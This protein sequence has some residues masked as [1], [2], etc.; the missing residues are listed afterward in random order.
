MAKPEKAN[1]GFALIAKD[2]EKTLGPCLA[3]IAPYVKQLVVCIDERT[4]DKTARI[5]R[6]YGAQVFPVKV[7]DWHECPTHG[8]VLAQD[9]AQ[10]RDVSFS[11]LD[12]DIEWWGWLDADDE[13]EGAEHLPRLLKNVPEPVI[14]FWSPYFYAYVVHEDGTRVPNTVFHRE[15]IFRTKDNEWKWQHRV[16]EVCTPKRQGPWLQANNLTWW[17]QHQQHKV[18]QSA[19]RNLLLLE[20]EYEEKPDDPRTVFYIGNQYFALGDWAPAADWYERYTRLECEKNPYELW[21]T[22]VYMSMAYER[23]GDLD[24]SLQAAHGAIDVLPQHPEPYYRLSQLAVLAGEFEK[25]IYWAGV[26]DAKE[27]PP[28]FVFKNPMDRSFNKHM[29]VADALLELGRIS[30]A[31]DTLKEALKSFKDERILEKLKYCEGREADIKTA[32]AY[33]TMA[34]RIGQDA[35][36]ELYKALPDTVKS[37]GRTRNITMTELRKRRTALTQPK[38]A[39]WCMAGWEP[40]APPSINGTG[41]GGSETAVIE[42]AKRFAQAGWLV[43]VYNGCDYMEGEYDGV[44]YWDAQRLLAGE[45]VDVLV[46][47]RQPEAH[48][49]DVK[50]R[51]KVL[52][53]HD[54]N[55]GP[56]R[57]EDFAA[58]DHVL[59]VSYWHAKRLEMYHGVAADY[60]PNGINLERFPLTKK[61][62]FRCVYASSPDRGLMKLLDL[63]PTIVAAEPAATL[64][65]AYGWDTA[66]KMIQRG[67]P[68]GENLLRMRE[69][70]EA[71]IAKLKGVTWRGRLPQDELAK[72]YSEAYLW[73]YP[74]DFL[75]VSCISAMESM[76][77][78]AVPVTTACGALPET[79]GASGLLVPSPTFSRGYG[80]TWART[81]IGLM[82]DPAKRKLYE[83]RGRARATE[84]TWDA[85]FQRW[86]D[87]LA[88]AGKGNKLAVASCD[89]PSV[90]PEPSGLTPTAPDHAP[91]PTADLVAA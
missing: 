60:V 13:L 77:G 5:A 16:H 17:H 61:V 9:F 40:W 22:Y 14:G 8:K 83:A 23:L 90:A 56:G 27:D 64:H 87:V 80:E 63:W 75:E 31:K 25:G 62:P 88:V 45:E 4:T 24:A 49:L 73:L 67:S 1:I 2:A 57:E 34:P 28:F 44:G 21:Q 78:G 81:A 15:R 7:S 10:A 55:A 58:W 59:G 48:A 29:P 66:E 30:E 32:E 20:I 76:A 38:I 85:A 50:A 35:A 53:M 51:Q 47:W 26:G 84:L 3:S 65:I 11:H 12:P 19:P 69:H 68:R 6:R 33:I 70:I 74:T 79:L 91:L 71:K 72:M 41:I 89:Q 52:W 54:L 86:L 46:G 39:F 43:D 36:L 82:I 18:E 42:I 37:F